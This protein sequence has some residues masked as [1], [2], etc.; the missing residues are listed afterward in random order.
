MTND[1]QDDS[2]LWS[3]LIARDEASIRWVI[4]RYAPGF[5]NY[6]VSHGIGNYQDAEDIFLETVFTALEKIRAYNPD[7]A[8]FSTWLYRI[9]RN[10]AIDFVRKNKK[11][12]KIF[13][14][15][16]ENEVFIKTHEGSGNSAIFDLFEKSLAQLSPEDRELLHL[17]INVGSCHKKI[18]NRLHITEVNSRAK[19]KRAIERLTTAMQQE[20]SKGGDANDE[21]ER[22]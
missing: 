18:A 16:E 12:R 2:A 8:R 13:V 15:L 20:R 11:A 19:L 22:G 14:P 5:M 9:G 7:Q 3:R 4:K 1:N 6:I 21:K 10:K 17:K